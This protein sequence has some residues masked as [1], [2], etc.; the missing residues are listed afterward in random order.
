MVVRLSVLRTGRLFPPR[1]YTWY[2]FLLGA[3]STPGSEGLCHWKIPMTPPGIEPATCRFHPSQ[4]P[5]LI[6]YNDSVENYDA[7]FWPRQ[8]L[9]LPFRVRSDNKTVTDCIMAVRVGTPVADERVLRGSDN[10]QGV[11]QAT[12]L[13]YF[14]FHTCIIGKVSPTP[15]PPTRTHQWP[16]VLMR[17]S[18]VARLLGLRVRIPQGDMDVCLLWV[19]DVLWGRGICVGLITRPEESYRLWRVVVCH[20]EISWMTRPWPTGGNCAMV[21]IYIFEGQTLYVILGNCPTWCTNSFQCI[22]LFIVLYMF[23]A[24]HAHHQEKQTVSI[25]LLV[26]VTVCWWQCRVLVGSLLPN[27]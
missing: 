1:K 18:A 21:Y 20:L 24:C 5:P 2:L 26:N 25:Q 15:H 11:V 4:L 12:E 16:R 3:E 27:I 14:A 9:N 10:Q 22:Y 23:R 8:T 6:P 19:L 17:G 7:N 13:Q